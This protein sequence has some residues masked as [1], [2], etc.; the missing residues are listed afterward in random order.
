[1]SQNM[2]LTPW[3]FQHKINQLWIENKCCTL[4]CSNQLQYDIEQ[5]FSNPVFSSP[6][7]SW[8]PFPPPL[9]SSPLPLPPISNQPFTQ[10]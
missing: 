2:I 4:E 3:Y 6:S 10:G 9:P 1:M 5:L 7:F 8:P